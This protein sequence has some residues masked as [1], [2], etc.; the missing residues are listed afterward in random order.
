V[1][2]LSD[3]NL[4]AVLIVLIGRAGGRIDITN[5]ELYDA[6]LT[7]DEPADGFMVEET[8]TGVR[9]SIHPGHA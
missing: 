7:G 2:Y 3:T 8:G 4:R 9:L 6:M 5:A 1:R